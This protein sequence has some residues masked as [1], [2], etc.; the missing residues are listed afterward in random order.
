MKHIIR[1]IIPIMLLFGGTLTGCNNPANNET[2][3]VRLSDAACTFRH[4]DNTPFTIEVITSPDNWEARSS[5]SWLQAERQ[6]TA[7]VLTPEENLR[8]VSA[9]ADMKILEE[10]GLSR[11]ESKRN[12]MHLSGGQR[13]RVAAR[14]QVTQLGDTTLPIIYRKLDDLHSSAISPDGNIVG[15]YYSTADDES[16]SKM[17]VVFIDLRTGER[18]E[19]GPYPESLILPTSVSCVTSQGLMYVVNGQGDMFAFDMHERN[20]FIPEVAGYATIQVNSSSA[21]GTKWVGRAT[22]KG[23]T[24]YVPLISENGTVRELPRRS[25]TTATN[26]TAWALSPAA[27][28]PTA[29]L[30]T[31]RFGTTSTSAWSI[32]TRRAMSIT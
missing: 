13:Q 28:P 6:G 16:Y 31:V 14:I 26:R 9:K 11:E 17:T 10:L 22:G 8:L 7:L 24:M 23:E 2:H 4:T 27:S 25:S 29:R 12:I 20:Y 15:G 32:G 21:Y 30:P 3:Y 1:R 5:G 19:F 18:T